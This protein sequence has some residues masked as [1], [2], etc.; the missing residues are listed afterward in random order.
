MRVL[1]KWACHRVILNTT[2]DHSNPHLVHSKACNSSSG[3]TTASAVQRQLISQRSSAGTP[4]LPFFF[5]LNK[6][7]LLACVHR[8]GRIEYDG[9]AVHCLVYVCYIKT[10]SLPVD[11]QHTQ[12]TILPPINKRYKLCGD[13]ATTEILHRSTL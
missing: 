4:P 10:F 8:A 12:W 2:R 11:M 5:R 7:G 9:M 6:P 13:K 1:S 3:K